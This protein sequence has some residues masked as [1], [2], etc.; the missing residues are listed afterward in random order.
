MAIKPPTLADL[1]S[2]G[3]AGF[4]VTCG[5]PLCLHSTPVA[6]EDLSLDPST[7]FP[8]VEKMHRF[9]CSVC[10]S[11]QLPTMPEWRGLKAS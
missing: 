8:A 4:Y 9:V 1:K 6:F 5:N 10:G 2:Q 7:P 3:F 11:R